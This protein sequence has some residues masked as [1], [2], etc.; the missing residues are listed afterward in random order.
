MP[1]FNLIVF[2]VLIWS[3]N[4]RWLKALKFNKVSDG[5]VDRYIVHSHP[6]ILLCG[7]I[8]SALWYSSVD[9]SSMY[10]SI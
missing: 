9:R 3:A 8:Y 10:L 4:R 1:D 2:T 6:V 7:Q 5:A